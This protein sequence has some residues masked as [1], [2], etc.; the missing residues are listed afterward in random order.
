MDSINRGFSSLLIIVLI[1]A[2]MALV[3]NI[4][5][6]ILLIAAGVWGITYSVRAFKKWN[7]NRD[8][9]FNRKSPGVEKVETM[10][11]AFSDSF[12]TENAIDVEFTEVK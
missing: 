8:K 1:F 5:P 2:A 10:E 7:S 9:V 12:N 4:L 11:G 6:V 3:L